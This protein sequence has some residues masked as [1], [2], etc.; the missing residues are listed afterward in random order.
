[1]AI[2]R[3]IAK[4]QSPKEGQVNRPIRVRERF[5]IR[6]AKSHV[7]PPLNSD[8]L[9]AARCKI[10][11]PPVVLL[12]PADKFFAL[13]SSMCNPLRPPTDYFRLGIIVAE[14]QSENLRQ[15]EPYCKPRASALNPDL[16][17]LL[18]PARAN[19]GQ[20]LSVLAHPK[21][22]RSKRQAQACGNPK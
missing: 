21:C 6:D 1:M 10:P 22:E 16:G 7:N 15:C 13:P 19:P 14:K 4:A 12:A 9:N 2:I 3:R 20:R 18:R 8:K 17:R 11:G 5:I